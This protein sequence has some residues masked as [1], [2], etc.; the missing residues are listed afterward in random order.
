[1]LFLLMT[2][3][4]WTRSHEWLNQPNALKYRTACD[5]LDTGMG[6]RLELS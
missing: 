1:M 6:A 4:V 3:S 2:D 5:K